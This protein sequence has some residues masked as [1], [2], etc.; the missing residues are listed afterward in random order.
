[1][2]DSGGES[3]IVFRGEQVIGIAEIPQ[4]ALLCFQNRCGLAPPD[5]VHSSTG[6]IG[7]FA[8]ALTDAPAATYRK[9]APPCSPPRRPFADAQR[10]RTPQLIPSIRDL[11][12]FIQGQGSPHPAPPA[13]IESPKRGR[14]SPR[15]IQCAQARL[16]LLWG[17]SG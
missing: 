8:L 3:V 13:T 6:I 15:G 7:M 14:A 5:V 11:C 9:R 4:P 2:I 17:G 16:P 10:R 12:G 1:M